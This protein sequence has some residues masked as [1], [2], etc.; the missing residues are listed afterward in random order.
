MIIN[1]GKPTSA[2]LGAIIALRHLEAA[3]ADADPDEDL[4]TTIN[5]ARD[6]LLAE[7]KANEEAL[8]KAAT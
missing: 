2:D 5:R 1:P 6:T 7:I 3:A 8:E 4:V